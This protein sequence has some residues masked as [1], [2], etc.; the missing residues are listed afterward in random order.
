MGPKEQT[1]G[2]WE[3]QA[4]VAYGPGF[5]PCIQLWLTDEKWP[6]HI[7]LDIFEAPDGTR[8]K[9]F[10]TTHYA[11]NN[12]QKRTPYLADFN[13][14]HIWVVEWTPAVYLIY[15]DGNQIVNITDKTL[16]PTTPHHFVAQTDMGDWAGKPTS[17]DPTRIELAL[18]YVRQWS[19]LGG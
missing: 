7:E 16:I 14:P 12:L 5:W 8:N 2:R 15:Q 18:D 17:K 4:S 19:Y 9:A 1:F 13:K 3:F 10:A 6:Q 11:S